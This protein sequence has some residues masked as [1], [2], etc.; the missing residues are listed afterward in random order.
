MS[1]KKKTLSL[2][3]AILKTIP[4]KDNESDIYDEEVEK[5]LDS[6][7]P[8]QKKALELIYEGYSYQ[9]IASILKR[10]LNTVRTLIRRARL[11]LKQK[12]HG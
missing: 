9:E 7:P 11:Y 6:L 10:P 8:D 12:Y 3:E 1:S 2:D 5:I 4:A